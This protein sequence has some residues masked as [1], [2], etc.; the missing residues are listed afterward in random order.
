MALIFNMSSQVAEESNRVSTGITEVIIKNIGRVAPNIKIDMGKLNH[1]IRK[2]AHFFTYFVL[3]ILV[4]NAFRRSGVIGY[5]SLVLALLICTLYA[6]SDEV[7]QLFV[8]GR[9]GQ[10]QDVI[11]DSLGAAAGIALFGFKTHTC[12]KIGV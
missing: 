12:V 10:V 1:I 11:I 2:N 3:G 9:G 6:I 8:P 4:L 7:H 5:R